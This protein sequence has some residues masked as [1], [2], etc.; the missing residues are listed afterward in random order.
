MIIWALRH[1]GFPNVDQQEFELQN[2]SL[3]GGNIS[4]YTFQLW[5]WNK[6]KVKCQSRA[7][8]PWRVNKTISSKEWYQCLIK[9]SLTSPHIQ[10]RDVLKWMIL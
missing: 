6:K 3:Q 10:G 1:F 4:Q 9:Y 7:K 2:L 5:P 8:I